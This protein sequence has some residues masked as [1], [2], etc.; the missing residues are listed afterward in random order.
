MSWEELVERSVPTV[1]E[2]GE[3]MS[4]MYEEMKKVNGG[5]LSLDEFERIIKE[6]N[7][8]IEGYI[9]SKNITIEQEREIASR[10]GDKWKRNLWVKWMRFKL[11][12]D[13]DGEWR[14]TIKKVET[15][16]LKDNQ[17]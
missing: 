1:D 4:W 3:Y 5:T 17:E 6:P 8:D 2:Y 7:F 16:L 14:K 12:G 10:L 13:W 9:I 15:D 11:H